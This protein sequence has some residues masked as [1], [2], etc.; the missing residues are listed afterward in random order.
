MTEEEYLQEITSHQKRI[1][2]FLKH[3]HPYPNEVDDILQESNI[4]L[5]SK[6][7]EFDS[8]KAFIPWALTIAR[9]TWMAHKQ[10]RRRSL[11]KITH[12]PEE[13]A[14]EGW[15]YLID[16]LTSSRAKEETE[17]AFLRRE[18]LN[19]ASQKLLPVEKA[20]LSLS[21]EGKSLSEIAEE[22]GASYGA[23]CARKRR[24]LIKLKK[25]VQH[26]TSIL[27]TS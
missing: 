27:Q 18:V 11:E 19:K 4:T 1:Y 7:A 6:Y 20:V 3:L 25:M 17:R 21:L 12:F 14:S 9:W 15:D 22:L 23:T 5:M 10:Q 13:I 16:P 2:S 8:S 26:E 24:L